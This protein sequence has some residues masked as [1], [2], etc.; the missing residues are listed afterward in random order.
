MDLFQ[1]TINCPDCGTSI[2]VNTKQLLLGY[3]FTCHNCNVSIGLAGDSRELV[4]KTIKKIDQFKKG[5][6]TPKV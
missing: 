5:T 2:A 3:K 1:S 6:P 4:E